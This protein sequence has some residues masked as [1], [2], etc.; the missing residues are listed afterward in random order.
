MVL[1]VNSTNTDQKSL[2]V[3]VWLI[4]LLKFRL[5][6]EYLKHYAVFVKRLKTNKKV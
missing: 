4:K 1:S 3:I 5:I 2:Q 6:S